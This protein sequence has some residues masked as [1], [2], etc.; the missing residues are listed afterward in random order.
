MATEIQR[1][2]RLLECI[3]SGLELHTAHTSSSILGDRSKYVGMSD[4]GS[5][6]LSCIS[7]NRKILITCKSFLLSR[8]ATGLRME[9]PRHCQ[10]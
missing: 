1:K 8:E 3:R 9:S 7:F 2:D 6:M 10:P 5:Y 4:I